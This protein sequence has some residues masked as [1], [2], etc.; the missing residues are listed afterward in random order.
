MTPNDKMN[1]KLEWM[2]QQREAMR[3]LSKKEQQREISKQDI[4][5]PVHNITWPE[6][7]EEKEVPRPIAISRHRPMGTR[8][9][10]YK[11][12]AAQSVNVLSDGPSYAKMVMDGT[13]PEWEHGWGD[14]ADDTT[15]PIKIDATNK[16]FT[17]QNGA[18]DWIWHI[19]IQGVVNITSTYGVPGDYEC[20]LSFDTN[21]G[22]AE[23]EHAVGKARHI[24]HLRP[25]L[26][27]SA[28]GT[29]DGFFPPYDM[30]ISTG[31]AT[32]ALWAPVK[33]SAHLTNNKTSVIAYGSDEIEAWLSITFFRF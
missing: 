13:V 30:S 24:F 8:R 33:P 14:P 25:G 3:H 1:L 16:I 21:N 10:K 27:A 31:K 15:W 6:R 22:G 11:T 29:E 2:R 26:T 5:S 28:P 7:P 9:I 17:F 18:E 19:F 4:V 20:S 12:W 23:T 32:L